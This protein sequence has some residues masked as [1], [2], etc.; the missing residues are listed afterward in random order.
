MQYINGTYPPKKKK[1][2]KKKKSTT[3]TLNGGY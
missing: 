2:E 3:P 1:R